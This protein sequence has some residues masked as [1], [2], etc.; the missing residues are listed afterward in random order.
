MS[1]KLSSIDF[2]ML[3]LLLLFAFQTRFSKQTICSENL[4]SDVMYK[5]S[6][7]INK[8]LEQVI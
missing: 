4:K 8:M 3:L 2:Y 6:Y 1:I 7:T 5:Q